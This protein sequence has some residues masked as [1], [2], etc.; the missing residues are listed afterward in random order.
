M[1]LSIPGLHHVTAITRDPHRNAG[2]YVRVLELALVK[3]TVSFDVPDVFH[4]YYGDAA[5]HPGTLLTFFVRLDGEPGRQG[6]GQATRVRFSVP[7]S[8]VQPWV[9]WLTEHGVGVER[10]ETWCGAPALSF[11][12]PDGLA[13]ELVGVPN[14]GVMYDRP[15]VILGLHSVELSMADPEPTS[16]LLTDTMG[17][18]I[19]DARASR[20]RFAMSGGEPGVFVDV[21][22]DTAGTDGMIGVGCVH[23]VAFRTED[24]AGQRAWQERLR[25]ADLDVTDVRDR[26]YFQSIYFHEPGGVR[27]EIATDGPGFSVDESPHALGSRLQ[28]PSPLEHAR[29]ELESRLGDLPGSVV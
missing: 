3:R 15:R 5:G 12:D 9:E 11:R 18:H 14:G 20:R 10:G 7:T 6:N 23:H 19:V 24:D 27:C 26:T 4:L 25:G 21:L 22:T 8:H 17:F 29:R 2:F 13:L 28:L 1:H 16:A